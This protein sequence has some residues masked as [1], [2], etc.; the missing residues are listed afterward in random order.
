[1]FLV[2]ISVRY[3]IV[4]IGSLAALIYQHSITPISLPCKLALPVAGESFCW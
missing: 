3:V 2:H 4:C 1:M